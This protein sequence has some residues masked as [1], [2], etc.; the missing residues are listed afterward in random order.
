MHNISEEHYRWQAEDTQPWIEHS[1]ESWERQRRIQELLGRLAGAQFGNR[2]YVAGD[3]KIFTHSL[4]MG[5]GSW[6]ASGAILRGDIRIAADCSVNPYAHLAGNIIIGRGCR[7]ASLASIYGFNH[8]HARTDI[9][10]KDQ[11]GTSDGVVLGDDVWI[12]ANV[13]VLD[14][15]TIGAHSIVAAGAVVTKSFPEFS[16]IGG[17]P[18]KLIKLRTQSSGSGSDAPAQ[19]TI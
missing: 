14:G 2:C 19:H 5:D 6:I 3:A 4:R 12:G 16:V 8:G 15:V 18:A 13:V 9:F 11:P 7:I 17:N 10:I 1:E